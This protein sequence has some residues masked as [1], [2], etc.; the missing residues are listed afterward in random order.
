M[1][2]KR[3]TSAARRT[4]SSSP[5]ASK[6]AGNNS[7]SARAERWTAA[8]IFAL[9]LL[10]RLLFLNATPDLAW[11]HSAL[12]KGDAPTWLAYAE[13]I[14]RGEPFDQGLPLRPPGNAYLVA[15]LAGD[16]LTTGNTRAALTRLQWAWCLLGAA[17]VLLLH[18]A[19]RRSFGSGPALAMGLLGAFSHGLMV[20]STSLNNETPY[21]FLVALLLWMWPRVREPGRWPVLIAWGGLNALACL[22]RVEH[23][24]FFA[25]TSAHLALFPPLFPWRTAGPAPAARRIA[26]AAAV[27]ALAFV[28]VLVPWHLEAWQSVREFNRGEPTLDPGTTHMLDQLEA[29]LAHINWSPEAQAARDDLPAVSRRTLANFVTATVVVRN[30]QSVSARDFTEILEGAFGTVPRFLGEFPFIA[31]YGGLNFYLANH[32]GAPPGFGRGPLD[33]P[34][35]LAGGASRYPAPLVAGLPPPDLALTYPPHLQI[36][37]EGYRLGLAWLTD[38]P[39]DAAALA[40][41]KLGIFWSG[42]TLGF[43][44]G[45]LPFTN[46]GLRRR[47]DLNVPQGHPLQLPWQLLWF[48]TLGGGLWLAR[49]NPAILPWL[50]YLLTKTVATVAFFGYARQGA[51]A[52]PVLALLTALV[53][54]LGYRTLV[55]PERARLGARMLAAAVLLLVATEVVRTVRPPEL[56]IDERPVT[57]GD[58]WPL[59]LHEDRRVGSGSG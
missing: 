59:E 24:L 9:A 47:V 46:Q 56:R 48:S 37:N 6:T 4:S 16:D 35:P 13:A 15:A 1:A 50:A 34:P 52:F 44:G 3:K 43:G 45:N 22:F 51:S 12:Y 49:R 5:P 54:D 25:L 27:V 8:G 32:E 28:A 31:I 26:G 58:P 41:E 38:H 30:G 17:T 29:A 42:A 18:L 11:P 36:V 40:V 10:L 55:G 39:A 21:L 57:S 23:A 19:V 33:L 20:L 7:P 2:Q 14:E 53:L